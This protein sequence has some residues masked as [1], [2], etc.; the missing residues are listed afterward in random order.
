MA[1]KIVLK[2]RGDFGSRVTTTELVER[3]KVS[4]SQLNELYSDEY[5]IRMLVFIRA[6]EMGKNWDQMQFERIV[7]RAQNFYRQVDK[8]TSMKYINNQFKSDYTI[9]VTDQEDLTEAELVCI[10]EES[11]FTNEPGTFYF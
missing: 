5:W 8:K 6:H 4:R 9:P 3:K 11:A 2:K 1:Q 7:K 10:L